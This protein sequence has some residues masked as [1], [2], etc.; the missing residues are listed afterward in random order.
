MLWK[1]GYESGE[2][3]T[4]LF[5]DVLPTLEAWKKAGRDLAIFS[6]GSIQAQLQFFSAVEQ[7]ETNATVDLRHL[8]TAHFDPA[9]AGSKLEQTSYQTI[10]SRL[11]R[12]PGEITFLTDNVSGA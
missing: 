3:K 7:P 8:F 1:Q 10:C 4:P 12:M 6:S 9:V 11:H 5:N 2:L